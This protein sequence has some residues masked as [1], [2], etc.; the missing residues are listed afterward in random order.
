MKKWILVVGM[1][2]VAALLTGCLTPKV[3]VKIEPNPI[4]LNA[5][6]LWK[7]NFYVKGIVLHLSTS[8]F[9]TN[10]EI[11]GGIV[12]VVDKDGRDVLDPITFD[13]G[14]KTP[15]V[16]GVKLR[17]NGPDFSLGELF[18]YEGD[19]TEEQFIAYYNENWQGKVYELSVTITGKNP[20]I[21]KADIRFE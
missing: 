6:Q 19:L 9:S 4:K 1:V 11:K 5:E 2:L 10:Y 17:E 16:P 13:I 14:E 15:I 21:G 8:G 7:D 20:T 12:T 3:N 18:D